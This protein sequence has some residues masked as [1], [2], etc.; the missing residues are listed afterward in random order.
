MRN[1][2]YPDISR[3]QSGWSPVN[4]GVTEHSQTNLFSLVQQWYKLT[5]PVEPPANASFSRR[6]SHR[7]AC[8]FSNIVCLLIMVLT[9]SVPICLFL[10]NPYI[11]CIVCVEIVI[12]GTSLLLNQQGRILTAG[13]V[14]VVSIEITL[15]SVILI[16]T[17]LNGASTQIL[18]LFILGELLAASLLP[19]RYVFLVALYNSLCIWLNLSYQFHNSAMTLPLYSQFISITAQGIGLE[20]MVAGISAICIYTTTQAIRRADKAEMVT[21]LEHTL[22]EQRKELE[23]DIEQILETH[24]AI[25][26]GN[27]NARVPI[28]QDHTLWH[29]AR[30]VNSLLVR[31]QRASISEKELQ[32]VEHAVTRTVNIIQKYEQQHQKALI[33]FTQTAIDPLIAAIQG[34]TFAF[35]KPLRQ[36]NR[37]PLTNPVNTYTTNGDFAPSQTRP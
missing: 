21:K 33:P 32:R 27:L 14:Q 31:L 34:K 19:I 24:V 15:T 26:N 6:D 20:F 36:Q 9:F 2:P 30:A 1:T 8:L 5:V 3:S 25:A 18:D 22:I 29:T 28:D 11:L 17:L 13:I 12:C 10:P 16:M 37:L 7:Q 23:S 35:T 4:K